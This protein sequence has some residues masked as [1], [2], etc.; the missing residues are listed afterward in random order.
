VAHDLL[1]RVR[2]MSLDLRPAPLDDLGLL[3]ALLWHFE[4]Y[5]ALTGVRVTFG[6][7]GL[8]QRRF[9]P[10][11]ETAAYRIAQEA[12]TN[13]ARH[14]RAREAIV[15]AS[16][17]DRVLCLE[18][19]DAGSGFDPEITLNGPRTAGVL[20]MRER[21]RLLQGRFTIDSAPGAGT[22]LRVELPPRRSDEE[23]LR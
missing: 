4:R 8:A 20:G 3:A 5:T 1:A 13:V 15:W 12:L 22:R 6:H 17:D 18:V 10:E 9:D 23:G 21:A 7:D 14:S 19:E 2:A 11:V 16:A